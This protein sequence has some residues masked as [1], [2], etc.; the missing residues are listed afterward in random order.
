MKLK[1]F[2]H[3]TYAFPVL[4]VIYYLSGLMGTGVVFDVIAGVLLTGS[5]LS[6]VHH[7]E[8]VA[9]KVGEPYGTIIL[10]LCITIIEVA[11]IVSLMVAGGEQAITLARDT[12]FAAVMII[13]NGII[14][15]CVLVGGVKYFE[16]FFARTSA[17]TYLVSIV[18]ILVITLVLPNFT[19]S[20]N[21]PY[22]NNAQLIFVSIAC[23][24]IYGVFLMVQ[25]VRHRSYFVPADG[26]A[27]EHFVP[28]TTQ[29]IVSFLLLVVCLIIV[30]LMAKGLSKTI[31][32]M[33]Q[34]MGAPKSLVGVIIAA[35]VLLPEGV[36]AIRAARNNQIQSS[37]NLALGSALASIGLSIPA[38]SAVSIM[39]DIPL[40]LG[41]DKKDIILLTLS[42]FIVM[43]SLSRGKT[44]ILYG[45]VLLVN[46]AAYIFTVI[47]P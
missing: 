18:S 38:I 22:Y 41:L 8:V 31:E 20:V 47:V 30:V 5:V 42:V 35:V 23:L 40:V 37:L 2:L 44:N 19:S 7:A 15:I 27:E 6:A 32:D 16:Q 36:A 9:H 34:S 21:G 46:L 17:T 43:L 26:N 33:V 4:A 11:L 13:L 45:T 28:N 25:T 1:E 10:A 12:V 3:Y 29:A 24:V 14:G 39:Y